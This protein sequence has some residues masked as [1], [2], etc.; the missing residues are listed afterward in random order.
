MK[1]L[2][3]VVLF[4]LISILGCGKNASTPVAQIPTS[5]VSNLMEVSKDGSVH[6]YGRKSSDS[7][8][9]RERKL[10]T[11]NDLVQVPV[12]PKYNV[13][14]FMINN[15]G[16]YDNAIF[17]APKIFVYAG[18][19]KARLNKKVNSDGTVTINLPIILVDGLSND[20]PAADGR[21]KI[22]LPDTMLIKNESE[23]R[24]ELAERYHGDGKKVL[25]ILPGCPQSVHIRYLNQEYDATP[26][27]FKNGD[28]CQMNAPF[29]ASFT[30]SADEAK[31]LLQE[32][33]YQNA[34]D[35]TVRFETRARISVAEMEIEFDK[36]KVFQKLE[37]SLTGKSL[38][39]EVEAKVEITKVMQE[40]M[41]K[42]RVAGDVGEIL[43]M[44]VNQAI[45]RFFEKFRPD[46]SLGNSPCGSG[47][48]CFKVKL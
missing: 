5:E 8:V 46:P 11:G 43:P 27:Q 35:V 47:P 2:N 1:K 4:F 13:S 9:E 38:F 20:I 48:V 40:E 41:M 42:V 37:T 7:E 39:A 45:E 12:D 15:V 18:E 34:V 16:V 21:T 10:Y 6:L 17:L 22:Q 3:L 26:L 36:N 28:Y 44:I 33:I 32:G 19:D 30:L 14:L 31:E 25:S 29:T 24:K 23:L